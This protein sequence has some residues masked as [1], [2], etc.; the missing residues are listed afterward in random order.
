MHKTCPTKLAPKRLGRVIANFGNTD[1]ISDGGGRIF[2]TNNGHYLE[3]TEGTETD[4]QNLEVYSTLLGEDLCVQFARLLDDG[5]LDEMCECMD[6]EPTT[7]RKKAKGR[8]SLRAQCILD[9]ATHFGWEEIDDQPVELSEVELNLRWFE[10]FNLEG[11]VTPSGC[12]DPR[13][14]VPELLLALCELDSAAHAALFQ[15]HFPLIPSAALQNIESSW[16][17]SIGPG[18]QDEIVVLLQDRC[19]AEFEFRWDEEGEQ[20]GFWPRDGS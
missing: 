5:G 4:G 17:D 3:Y 16:W 1:P 14:I 18:A 15:R 13:I 6:E 19:P 9:L 7:W 11:P 10:A 20:F 2:D 8:L 12:K